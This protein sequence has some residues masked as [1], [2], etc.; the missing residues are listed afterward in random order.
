MKKISMTMIASAL[1]LGLFTFGQSQAECGPE[2]WKDCAGKPW[3]DGDN[4][5][6]P[7]GSK[8]WPNP[9]WG[10]GDEAGSTNWYTNP[11]VVRRALAQVK[12]G[13]VYGLAHPY[14]A[15]MPL[16]GERGFALRI[17]GTPS[18]GPFGANKLVYHDDYLATEISQVGTQFDGLGHIGVQIG[19][20][21]D[22]DNMRWYNGFTNTEVGSAYGMTK[23]GAEKLH[24][25]VARGI[26]IDLAAVLGDMEAGQ[27][28][29]M[30]DVRATLKKQGMEDFEFA[31]GDGIFFRYGWERNW[32]DPEAYNVGCPGVDMSVARWVAEEVKAGVTGGD[33]WPGTD[34]VPYP[35]EEACGFC[36]HTYLQTRHGIVNHENLALK[37][38]ADAG[39]YVFAYIFNPA[40]IVGATGS[41][42]SPV[43]IR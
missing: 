1:A 29:T 8:W 6:T 31:E 18:G 24:P 16:F 38:L 15:K 2:S 34:P 27:A 3:V 13:K 12:T 5:E 33:T 4:M 40:P 42:G 41:I 25:I 9:L 22:R 17:P 28:A 32:E 7:L 14:H 30:E 35:G 43:A 11:E 10:E 36:I 23:L 21:G 19:A 20:D 37:Q 26:L 39:V